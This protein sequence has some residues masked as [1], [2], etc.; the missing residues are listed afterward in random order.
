MTVKHFPQ[1]TNLNGY[2]YK[3]LNKESMR[4]G[5]FSRMWNFFF[6]VSFLFSK[7]A[8]A[9]QTYVCICKR[10][11]MNS[12]SVMICISVLVYFTT[13][14]RFQDLYTVTCCGLTIYLFAQKVK[15]YRICNFKF[16]FL[17][18]QF[19]FASRRKA[20]DNKIKQC[21]DNEMWRVVEKN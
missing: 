20:T 13:Y 21:K 16:I 19:M 17:I 6:A 1:F 12:G 8:S 14:L 2:C 18:M 7:C 15:T 11:Q 4:M 10:S 3:I 9:V 5:T